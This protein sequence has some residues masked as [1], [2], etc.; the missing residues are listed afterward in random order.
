MPESLLWAVRP[1]LPPGLSRE[2]TA[3]PPLPSAPRSVTADRMEL[4]LGTNYLSSFLLTMRLLPYLR[5]A[6]EELRETGS[7]FEARM[8]MVS[9]KLHELGAINIK[10]PNLTIKY[11]PTMAYGQ[12]KLAQVR[13]SPPPLLPPSRGTAFGS[14]L[15]ALPASHSGRGLWS[16]SAGAGPAGILA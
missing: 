5:K 10:D 15:A 16:G 9:S 8:V 14:P 4:H 1:P 13:A 6:G 3:A 11:S 12:S 2:L 7:S